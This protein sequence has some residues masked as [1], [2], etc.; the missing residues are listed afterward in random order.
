MTNSRPEHPRLAPRPY[1]DGSG[2]YVETHWTRATERIGH[3]AT[4]SEARN[5]ITLEATSYFVLR[6]LGSMMKHS[7]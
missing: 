3:F 2:W 4:Y 5:W 7:A 1:E 6:E